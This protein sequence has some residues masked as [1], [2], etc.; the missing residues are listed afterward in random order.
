MGVAATVLSSWLI[1]LMRAVY[2]DGGGFQ[3][4]LANATPLWFAGVIGVAALLVSGDWLLGWV[5]KCL[6]VDGWRVPGVLVVGIG[7]ALALTAAVR[8]VIGRVRV[9][10]EDEPVENHDDT[11]GHDSSAGSEP[12][13]GRLPKLPPERRRVIVEYALAYG[14]AVVVILIGVGL[15]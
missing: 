14:L 1:L 11:C 2:R 7:V 12:V 3:R 8:L 5:E 13:E 6:P 15:A 4:S 9:G 10:R